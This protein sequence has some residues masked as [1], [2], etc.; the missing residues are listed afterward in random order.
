MIKLSNLITLSNLCYLFFHIFP[1][2]YL[3]VLEIIF[4]SLSRFTDTLSYIHYAHFHIAIYYKKM[5][6]PENVAPAQYYYNA[7]EAEKYTSNS[8]IIEVQAHMSQ[9][10]IELLQLPSSGCLVL[11]LGCGS[12]LSG[13]E[14][15]D[16][17]HFWIGMDISPS[18][19]LVALDR[20]VEGDLMLS[21]I[22]N[23]FHFAP[24]CFDG[25]ISISAL[26]WLCNAEKASH[27]PYKRFSNLFNS[28]YKSLARGARAVFQFY[29][30]HPQQIEIITQSAVKAGFMADMVIDFPES[31][32]AKKYYL[33]LH[34]GSKSSYMNPMPLNDEDEV[35]VSKRKSV[36]KIKHVKC[37]NK[38]KEWIVN[39]KDRQRKQGKEIRPD[40]KYTGRK[41]HDRF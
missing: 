1:L 18:M 35:K 39:K 40:S 28:L 41:R 33:I 25:C 31:T 5:S 37:K 17:G 8:R 2:E 14:L 19:L 27:N 20:E 6:R 32:K 7:E 34:T 10:A 11:D 21:D 23:G 4:Y 29:P 12:G 26:Q 13:S 30:A 38:S 16:S 3:E 15:S 36:K 24:G 22:G 9:R